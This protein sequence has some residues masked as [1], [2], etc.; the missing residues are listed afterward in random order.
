MGIAQIA[1]DPHPLLS[2][3]QSWKKSAQTILTSPYTPGQMWE[4]SAPI[5]PGK[6][7][8]PTPLSGNAHIW[9]QHISKKGL[10]LPLQ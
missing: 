9:K 6:P 2:N 8:H 5:H 4:K 3:G 7:L 1:L 10:P